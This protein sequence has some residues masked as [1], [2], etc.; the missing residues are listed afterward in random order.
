[1]DGQPEEAE[2]RRL[3]LA[4]APALAGLLAAYGAE[5]RH[6]AAPDT[7]AES[8]ARALLG[9]ALAETLGAFI[10]GRLVAFA[11][12][13]DLPEAISGSRAGQLDD[14]Y[15]TPQAR[16]HRLARRLIDAVAAIGRERGWVHLRWLVPE[17]NADAL[18]AYD[19][20][21]EAAPWKSYALWLGDGERW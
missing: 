2:I 19:R 20:F 11:I 14:L 13:F 17:G 4:D 5:M 15:V 12:V 6:G 8:R 9:D 1:M 16:G 3:S 18:R 7:A 21:A 10:G